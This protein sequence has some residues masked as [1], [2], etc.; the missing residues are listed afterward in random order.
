MPGIRNLPLPSITRAPSV[1][2]RCGGRATSRMRLPSTRT[3]PWKVSSPLPSKTLTLVIAI[4][5][6][7]VSSD[8]S[9]GGINQAGWV[10]SAY[11][12][13]ELLQFLH[14]GL[15]LLEGCPVT[16]A[17]KGNRATAPNAL[18]HESY[19]GGWCDTILVARYQQCR[20]RDLLDRRRLSFGE[21]LAALRVAIRGLAHDAFPDKRQHG[22]LVLLRL[23]A[24]RPFDDGVGNLLHRCHTSAGK[25]SACNDVRPCRLRWCDQGPEE[26]EGSHHPRIAHCE[27]LRDDG[28]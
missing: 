16:A 4:L 22:R 2:T 25:L 3:S 5:F 14:A 11:G 23:L 8:L 13:V 27:M 1:F 19:V 21:R 7:C 24:R 6:M 12:A 26:R 18:G 28:A 20:H 15:R 9:G 17:L 10:G